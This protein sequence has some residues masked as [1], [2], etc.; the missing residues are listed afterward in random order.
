MRKILPV[1]LVLV[2]SWLQLY[3]VCDASED[4]MEVVS[5]RLETLSQKGPI[6]RS[7]AAPDDDA[8]NPIPLVAGEVLSHGNIQFGYPEVSLLVASAQ[9]LSPPG[10]RLTADSPPV[11][12]LVLDRSPVHSLAP[13]LA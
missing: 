8:N 9:N 5:G 1:T 13:P 11:S 12:S 10:R 7:P 2:F 3:Q 4:T 6:L